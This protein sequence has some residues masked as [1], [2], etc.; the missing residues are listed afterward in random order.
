MDVNAHAFNDIQLKLAQEF[1]GNDTFHVV[2][3]PG[4]S[5]NFF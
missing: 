4:I 5:G 3:Q 2:V 1:Q